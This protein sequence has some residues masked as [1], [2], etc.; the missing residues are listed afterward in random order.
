VIR[1]PKDSLD[2][3]N[4]GFIGVYQD[5]SWE[6]RAAMPSQPDRTNVVLRPSIEDFSASQGLAVF[7][8]HGDN[9]SG[10]PRHSTVSFTTASSL[11]TVASIAWT[12][13]LKAPKENASAV[14][15]AALNDYRV[16]AFDARSGQML[17]QQTADIFGSWLSCSEERDILC[18]RAPAPAAARSTKSAKE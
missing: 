7:D 12:V 16:V 6:E 14:A 8:R 1:V 13:C 2:D 11:A 17:W 18:K 5:C 9:C 15:L 10:R 3:P 4:W